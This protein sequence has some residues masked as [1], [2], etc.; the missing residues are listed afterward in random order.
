MDKINL[1]QTCSRLRDV[2]IIHSKFEY[3]KF[4]LYELDLLTLWQTRQFLEMAGPQIEFL[5]GQVPFKQT[6]RIIEFLGN[7][8]INVK[9]VRINGTSLKAHILR[10]LLK[11]MTNI[12]ELHLND[13]E[14]NDTCI[15]VLKN[16]PNLKIL[17]LDEN[18]EI[19]GKPYM[20]L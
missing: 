16:L 17:S 20:F 19:T 13:T 14:C 8:C 9:N 15:P 10:K 11:K 5:E 7:F 6:K 12:N 2:F 1:S 4:N 18:C 3:K